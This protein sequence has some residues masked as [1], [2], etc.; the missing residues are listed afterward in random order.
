MTL[1][2]GTPKNSFTPAGSRSVS[3]AGCQT[4]TRS[5]STSWKRSLSAEAT[6]TFSPSP[7]ALSA[8]VAIRS[9]ASNP[10]SSTTASPIA[11][12]S[13][14]ASSICGTRSSGM[15]ARCAL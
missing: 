1:S 11:R 3:F 12:Q 8:S 10:G 7:F 15:A 13:R 9:S 5:P 2:G 4:A 6:S 14:F